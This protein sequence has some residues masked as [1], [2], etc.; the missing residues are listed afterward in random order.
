[1]PGFSLFDR[2]GRNLNLLAVGQANSDFTVGSTD[3]DTI[4]HRSVIR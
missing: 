4:Q 1:L 3:D 2:L